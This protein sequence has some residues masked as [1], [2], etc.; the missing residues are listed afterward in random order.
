MHTLRCHYSAAGAAALQDAAQGRDGAFDVWWSQQWRDAVAVFVQA[1]A[2]PAL[3]A[4]AERHAER[5]PW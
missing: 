5:L 2:L 3:L 1:D 4:A